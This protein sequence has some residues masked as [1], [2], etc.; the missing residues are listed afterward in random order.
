MAAEHTTSAA[1]VAGVGFVTG[2]YTIVVVAAV[3]GALWPLANA[4]TQTRMQGFWLIV[5]LVGTSCVCASLF[6]YLAE[7][8]LGIPASKALGPVALVLA[9]LGDRWGDIFTALKER[10]VATISGSK[11]E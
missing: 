8:H 9:A 10:I 5:R 2:D 1:V 7:K 11:K 3:I 4:S 6:T